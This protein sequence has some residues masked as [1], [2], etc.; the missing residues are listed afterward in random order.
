MVNL[1]YISIILI[2]LTSIVGYCMAM[3][4]SNKTVSVF[5]KVLAAGVILALSIVHIIPDVIL[6]NP[7]Q[8]PYGCLFVLLGIFMLSFVD[9]L[10]RHT[11]NYNN[12]IEACQARKRVNPYVFETAC[13]FHSVLIGMSLGTQD[14]ENLTPLMITITIHQFIEGASLG[15]VVGE[16]RI[17]S[18]VCLVFL[19]SIST[20]IGIFI[21]MQSYNE[22]DIGWKVASNC[23]LGLSAGLLIY[24][25]LVQIFI[26]EISKSDLN[27]KEVLLMYATLFAGMSI[28][29]VMAIWI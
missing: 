12:D 2:I 15:W 18:K 3:L 26:G 8:Y 1:K 17:L 16:M 25:S 20:P 29:S 22:N 4:I 7:Y 6:D 23:L 21:G 13:V 9:T 10:S 5:F 24:I 11:D 19:Y 14:E 28:M 27:K